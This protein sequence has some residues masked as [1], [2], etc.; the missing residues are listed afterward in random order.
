MHRYQKWLS[1]GLLAL[2]PGIA[3]A[4]AL[5]SPL[6]KQIHKAAS[7][8]SRPAKKT[9][10]ELNQDLA[11]KIAKAMRAAKLSGYDIDIDVRDGMVVL[12]GSVTSVAQRNVAAKVAR[13]VPGVTGV[14]NR[15]RIGDRPTSPRVVQ[16][17]AETPQSLA[18]P[19]IVRANYQSGP[20][21]SGPSQSGPSL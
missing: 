8:A 14:N 1:M 21:Q 10:A 3:A 2:T 17:A 11:E 9:R 13:S 20:T 19:Y 12:D 4:G 6:L 15:L 7:P 16:S 5:D 18:Q